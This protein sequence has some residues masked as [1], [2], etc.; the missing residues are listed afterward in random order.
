[1][2]KLLF[3]S[4]LAIGCSNKDSV[5]YDK[6]IDIL[7]HRADEA[8]AISD[9]IQR[10]S[11]SITTEV[12]NQTTKH[13][14][15]IEKQSVKKIEKQKTI[16]KTETIYRIDTIYVENKKNFWGKTKTK[17]KTISD[18]TSQNTSD[19][20]TIESDSTIIE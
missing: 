7:I 11:D 10:V 20:T 5:F 16:Y 6:K 14:E 4:L 3:F 8:I 13:F 12:V 15:E 9:S 19:S 18:S 17:I 1:M 2:K